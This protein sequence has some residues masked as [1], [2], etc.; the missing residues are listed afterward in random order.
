MYRNANKLLPEEL[1]RQLQHYVQGEPIYV[2]CTR[3]R[4]GWGEV[5]GTRQKILDRNNQIRQ[6][7]QQ[8]ASIATLMERYHLGYDSIRKITRKIRKNK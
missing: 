7:Y 5:N 8:G 4:A 1:L 6:E 3:R 2:P